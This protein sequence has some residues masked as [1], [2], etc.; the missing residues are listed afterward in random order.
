MLF[1]FQVRGFDD[2]M[3]VEKIG[4]YHLQASRRPCPLQM[5][6]ISADLVGHEVM[7]IEDHLKAR[8]NK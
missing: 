2:A 4:G 5:L 6:A 3:K 1:D 8:I 7:V